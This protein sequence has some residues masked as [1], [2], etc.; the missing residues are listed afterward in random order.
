MEGRGGVQITSRGIDFFHKIIIRRTNCLCFIWNS[1]LC[2]VKNG[3]IPLRDGS[4]FMVAPEPGQSTEDEH[5]L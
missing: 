5:F 4:K 1:K 3:H 2:Q